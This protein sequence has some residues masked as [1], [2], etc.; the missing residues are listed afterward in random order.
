LFTDETKFDRNNRLKVNQY[1]QVEGC[2]NVYAIGDCINTPE[3]K[4]AAHAT[5]HAQT[6][7][8]NLLREIKGEEMNPY[9]QSNNLYIL[10]FLFRGTKRCG[11]ERSKPGVKI[12]FAVISKYSI[13]FTGRTYQ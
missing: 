8:A 10:T 3:A 5:T 13:E 11:A 1:L 2:K 12:K 9:K 7:A 6:V 4:M